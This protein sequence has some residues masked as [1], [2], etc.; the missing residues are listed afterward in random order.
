METKA[1]RRHEPSSA[2]PPY[3]QPVSP[4]PVQEAAH[5][6]PGATPS[7]GVTGTQSK[8]IAR[9]R[10]EQELQRQRMIT[11]S[12]SQTK[13]GGSQKASIHPTPSELNR[14]KRTVISQDNT[15]VKPAP[16]DHKPSAIPPQPEV[17]KTVIIRKRTHSPETHGPG[18]ESPRSAVQTPEDSQGS[19]KT[20]R[21]PVSIKEPVYRAKDEVFL[22]RGVRDSAVP[23]A[24]DSTL[25]HTSLKPKKNTE[26][27]EPDGTK[28]DA[29]DTEDTPEQPGKKTKKQDELSWI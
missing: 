24:R 4:K 13:T 28:K 14:P 15:P 22:G 7:T 1:E 23:K 9:Q 21:E 16:P 8:E 18:G 12:G 2:P 11:L 5:P 10:I 25:I 20:E 17:K 3:Q 6:M 26:S 19:Q 29:H 27:M